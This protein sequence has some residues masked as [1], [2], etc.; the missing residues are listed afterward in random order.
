MI[1]FEGHSMTCGRYKRW[2]GIGKYDLDG[3]VK[4]ARNNGLKIIIAFKYPL[5]FHY[6]LGLFGK[7]TQIKKTES[8]WMLAGHKVVNK[9]PG[10]ACGFNVNI[11]LKDW[12]EHGL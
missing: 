11:H 1:L 7:K 8:E 4:I 2:V 9:K 12:A 6:E 5:C 3:L 10:G